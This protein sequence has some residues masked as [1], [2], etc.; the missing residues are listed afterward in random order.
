MKQFLFLTIIFL[1]TT[2][3]CNAD[4]YN[5]KASTATTQQ[6]QADYKS[7]IEQLKQLSQQYK[8]VSGHI[9]EVLKETGVPTFDENSGE[10]KMVKYDPSAPEAKVLKTE[11]ARIQETNSDMT[12]NLDLPGL[13]KRSV[14]ISIE[15][16]NT[17]KIKAKRKTGEE[18]ERQVELPYP[19][20]DKDAK[21]KYEDGVLSVIV[22]KATISK[23]SVSVP[24]Q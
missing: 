22:P 3:A 24:L 2:A 21:A 20:K 8:Q 18:I 23:S 6:A 13:D 16:Q 10:I 7:Y 14:S 17:L 19:A 5:T 4:N 9:Q 15:Q 12:V 11:D 1:T